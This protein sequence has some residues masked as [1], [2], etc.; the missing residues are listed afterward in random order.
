MPLVGPTALLRGAIAG[1]FSI[2]QFNARWDTG[3]KP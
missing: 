2:R 3:K 1:I